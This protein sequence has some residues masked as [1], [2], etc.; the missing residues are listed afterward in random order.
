KRIFFLF[1]TITKAKTENKKFSKRKSSFK[2]SFKNK[3]A[4]FKMLKPK[5]PTEVG[6]TKN[7]GRKQK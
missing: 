1:K 5:M 6:N 7:R 4:L 2:T 3:K